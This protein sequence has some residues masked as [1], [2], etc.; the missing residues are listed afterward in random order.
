[1]ANPPNQNQTRAADHWTAEA[2]KKWTIRD[3]Y[4]QNARVLAHMNRLACGRSVNSEGYGATLRQ[5][6]LL[7]GTSLERGVSI[8][9]GNAKKEIALVKTGVVRFMDLFEISEARVAQARENILRNDMDTQLS[10]SSSDPF[11][12]TE[13]ETYDLVYW[14]MALHHMEDAYQAIEWSHRVLKPGG[15]IC[16]YELVGPKRYQWTDEMVDI[17]G[18]VRRILP[19]EWF[20]DYKNTGKPIPRGIKRPHLR[21]FIARDPS[22]ACDS[23]NIIPAIKAFFPNPEIR[24]LGGIIYILALDGIYANI[25]DTME[26]NQILDTLLLMDELLIPQGLSIMATAHAQKNR[27]V[28]T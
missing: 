11:S 21:K 13:K 9:C 4:F 2:N 16:L 25:K 19:E 6:E 28:R 7:S 26:C 27:F 18:R 5:L 3:K 24:N 1:M 23:A 20:R 17:V 8:G 12:I 14:N 22:E 10:V 15:W